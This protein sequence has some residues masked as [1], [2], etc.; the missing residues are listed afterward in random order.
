MVRISWKEQKPNEEVF[1]M[2]KTSL[3][4]MKI[5][6]KRKGELLWTFYKKTK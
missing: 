1:N 3:K 4:L 5:I 2:M 6:K